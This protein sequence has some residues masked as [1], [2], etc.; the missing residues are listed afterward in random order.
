MA[1]TRGRPQA[2][3]VTALHALPPSVLDRS[4]SIPCSIPEARASR[5]ARLRMQTSK[6]AACA[7]R[8][9]PGKRCVH[10]WSLGCAAINYAARRDAMWAASFFC[11]LNGESTTTSQAYSN[12]PHLLS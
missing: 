8:P 11:W 1:S 4:A 12:C 9:A 3:H 2:H 10:P 6:H 5:V 7:H